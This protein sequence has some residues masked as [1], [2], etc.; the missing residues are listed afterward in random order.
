MG[1]IQD[2]A[3][4]TMEK[5]FEKTT[6]VV[7]TKDKLQDLYKTGR[8]L[9]PIFPTNKN[10]IQAYREVIKSIRGA[11]GRDMIAI[12][13]GA[14]L[15]GIISSFTMWKILNRI[16]INNK[17]SS[18]FVPAMSRIILIPTT[19]AFGSIIG[20][21]IGMGFQFDKYADLAKAVMKPVSPTTDHL[22]RRILRNNNNNTK[23]PL[24]KNDD[25]T[26]QS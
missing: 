9:R 20:A 6:E 26:K 24:E 25:N 16:I 11:T 4:K 7:G 2:T 1:T 13:T 19:F 17:S 5:S 21:G 10:E 18:S 3:K 12:Y 23:S 14:S 8:Y 15:G 22:L